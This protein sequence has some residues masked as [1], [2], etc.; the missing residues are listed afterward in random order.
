MNTFSGYILT[1]ILGWNIK[2][3][4]PNLNKSIVI[5]AP[6]T[7]W[8][9]GLIGKLYLTEM[10]IRHRFLSK[11]ELF[12]F[13]MNLIMK[14]YGSIPVNRGKDDIFKVSEILSKHVNM[15]LVLSPE[16]TRENVTDWKKGFY[17]IA[18][19]ADIPIVVGYID[20]SKKEIGVIKTIDHMDSLVDIMKSLSN[21]YNSSMARYPEKFAS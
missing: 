7:S 14:W 19:R 5:F 9:D 6:H 16:G 20:Y 8:Y 4:F 13:P 3:N 15:H 11:R 1:S 10:G 18:K 17:Y 21:I 2:G 12:F